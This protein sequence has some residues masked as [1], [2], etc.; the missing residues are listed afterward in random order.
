MDLSRRD[1]ILIASSAV[2]GGLLVKLA[3]SLS[4]NN[5]NN[6]GKCPYSSNS[7]NNN[8]AASSSTTTTATT[9]ANSNEVA[10]SKMKATYETSGAVAQYLLFHYAPLSDYYNYDTSITVGQAYG[11]PIRVAE[12]AAKFKPANTARA[13]DLGCAVGAS[14]FVL[15]RYFDK[16]VGVDLSEAFIRAANEMKEKGSMAYEY[17]SQGSITEVK[18]ARLGDVFPSSTN[19]NGSDKP[20]FHPSRVEF[21][22]GDAET[23]QLGGFDFILACNLV[24]RVPHPR[25]LIQNLA[26]HT[27]KGGILVILTPFSWTEESTNRSEWIGGSESAG[28]RS[29]GVFKALMA[30]AGFELVDEG[31]EPHLIPDHARRFQL[32]FPMRTVWRKI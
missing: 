17:V 21:Q 32:G 2:A 6:N 4:K 5:N 24:C 8:G 13:L 20:S 9:T 27:N 31:F 16:V 23:I 18:Y 29:E 12:L 28:G 3:S 7:N 25:K 26:N 10:P 14:S 22:T 15:S 1:L 19:S 30:A 11:F